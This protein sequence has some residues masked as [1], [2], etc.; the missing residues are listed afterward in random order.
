MKHDVHI[1]IPLTPYYSGHLVEN[2][3]DPLLSTLLLKLAII[4]LKLT[5]SQVNFSLEL[6]RED[7]KL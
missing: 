4:L 1:P 3:V 2:K 6:E 7:L 5:L